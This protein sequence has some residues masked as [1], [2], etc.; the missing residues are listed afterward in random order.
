MAQFDDGKPASE[1]VHKVCFACH[2]R[3]AAPAMRAMMLPSWYGSWPSA[4]PEAGLVL[5]NAASST[6]GEIG[7]TT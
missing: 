5:A 1:A 6:H 7:V 4:W 2:Q 3:I